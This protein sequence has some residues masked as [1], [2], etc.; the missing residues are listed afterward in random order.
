[1]L[2]TFGM[3]DLIQTGDPA[4]S[5]PTGDSAST[6]LATTPG[7][8]PQGVA[9]ADHGGP[10]DIAGQS[11]G[12]T[13]LQTLIDG[14]PADDSDLRADIPQY[15]NLIQQRQQL[16]T[17]SNVVRELQPLSIFRDLGDPDSVKSKLTVYDL[18][19]SPVVHNGQPVRDPDT[20]TVFITTKPLIEHLDKESPGMPEQLFADLLDYQPLEE[21]GVTRG[22]KLSIQALNYWD[23]TSPDWWRQR[24][25][26]PAD[27][28]LATSGQ[29]T[30]EEL[31][32]IPTEFHE[33]YR[34]M[35]SAIRLKWAAY[36]TAEQAQLLADYKAKVDGMKFAEQTRK[37]AERNRELARQ[38]YLADVA[39]AQA[40][41]FDRVRRERFSAL[42]KN[43]ADQISFSTDEGLNTFNVGEIGTTLW[44]L[45]DPEGRFIAEEYVLKPLGIKL[46]HTLDEAL[47]KFVSNA[48]DKV[49][50]EM[51]GHTD[52]ARTAQ[53]A[54]KDAADQVMAKL[55][56]IAMEIAKKKGGQV[57]ARAATTASAFA[58]ATT[59][60]P[61][62]GNGQPPAGMASILPPGIRPGSP[63]A[64][65]Y[66]AEQTGFLQ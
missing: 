3:D 59:A 45:I 22:P 41:Y 35:P 40:Q 60:R 31:A 6:A 17:L 33:A 55:F 50:L 63:E 66:L 24:Y 16:R 21:D 56:T 57:K 4:G 43:I 29:I 27:A 37:E 53:N 61:S 5:S 64:I 48:A 38:R 13:D 8:T 54:A 1:M 10:A 19:Y 47:D 34:A 51:A 14:I 58:T 2:V 30:P 44:N 9:P 11:G 65:R 20:G 28:P 36:D 23:K 25:G 49:A 46:D 18:L 52:R 12:T 62:P 26:V 39:A 7:G 32:E 42:A 15:Q